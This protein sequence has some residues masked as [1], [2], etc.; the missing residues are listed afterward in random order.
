M[1][2]MRERGAVMLPYDCGH[3]WLG[4]SAYGLRCATDCADP[5]PRAVGRVELA[6][7]LAFGARE[8]AEELLLDAGR[9]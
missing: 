7:F 4:Q 8:L 3:S 1:G 9:K 2:K 5:L 6:T